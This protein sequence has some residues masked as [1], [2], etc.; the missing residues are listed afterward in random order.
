MVLGGGL[1]V[2]GSNPS[3]VYWKDIFTHLFVDKKNL[4]FEKTKIKKAGKANFFKKLH[5]YFQ[6]VL[7]RFNDFDI[8]WQLRVT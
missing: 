4:M 1:K 5:F 8:R 7:P 6:L 3:A 2:V